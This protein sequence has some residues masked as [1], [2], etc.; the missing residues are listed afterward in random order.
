MAKDEMIM[1]K[2]K[3]LL[4][5]VQDFSEIFLDHECCQLCSDLVKKLGRKREVPFKRGKLTIWASAVIHVIAHI[6]FLFDQKFTPHISLDDICGYFNTNK[7]TVGS[8]S[9]HIRNI[10]KINYFHM[11]FTQRKLLEEYLI[12]CFIESDEGIKLPLKNFEEESRKKLIDS[13]IEHKGKGYKIIRPILSPYFYK[14]NERLN[15]RFSR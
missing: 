12:R 14:T 3:E 15:L 13:I 10:L 7:S 4:N 1:K 9:H 6:N 2:E 8:K 5:M 11:E